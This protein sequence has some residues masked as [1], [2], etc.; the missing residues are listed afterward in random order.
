MS[1]FFQKRGF[2]LIETMVAVSILTLAVAGPLYSASR[3]IVAAVTARD[4]L[5]AS[6]LAQEGIEYVRAMRDAT[7]L[8]AAALNHPETAWADFLNTSGAGVTGNIGICRS[9][10][11]TLDP[12]L[13]MGAG[14]GFALQSCPGSGCGI[15]YLAPT[16][17]YTQTVSGTATPFTRTVQVIDAS[18]GGATDVRVVSTVR[19]INHGISHSTVVSDHLTPW[20]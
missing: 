19:W 10:V 1:N 7:F 20:Q 4:Q 2:T 13:P 12:T 9:A 11:C 14:G 18:P 16:R 8:N 17:V 5:I 15:L 6:Y 3:A